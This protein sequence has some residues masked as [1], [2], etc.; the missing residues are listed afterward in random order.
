[1][2]LFL[3]C[4][5][6]FFV[7]IID[8]SMGTVRTVLIVRGKK[9][10]GSLI[11]FVEILVWFLIVSKALTTTEANLWIAIAYAGGFSAGTFVGSWLEEKLA[12]GI[13]S[14]NVIA[15]G[16]R[17]DLA[18]V[19]R[20]NGFAV[21]TV[22]CQGRDGDNLLLLIQVDRKNILKLRKLI[23]DVVPDAFISVFDTKQI[24]NGYFGK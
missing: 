6:I 10:L 16:L 23:H 19:I 5:L 22:V 13:S 18:E 14:M 9:Y 11:G 3:S 8:V 17:Y 24:Y 21:S 4:L 1:M 20:N 2:E 15:K 12:I 7:R